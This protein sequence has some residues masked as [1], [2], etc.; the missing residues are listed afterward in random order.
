MYISHLLL[1]VCCLLMT[2]LKS[3]H[4]FCRVC[5]EQWIRGKYERKEFILEA[6]DDERPYTIG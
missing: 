2:C 4:F 3:G 1:H 6:T 5:R